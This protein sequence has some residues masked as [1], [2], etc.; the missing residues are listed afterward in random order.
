[1]VKG[2]G[3]TSAEA[4]HRRLKIVVFPLDGIPINPTFIFSP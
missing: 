1:V 3:A 2:Y 4:L